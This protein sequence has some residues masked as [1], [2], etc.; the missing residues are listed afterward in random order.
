MYCNKKKVFK[1]IFC[2][3]YA[4]NKD[5]TQKFLHQIYIL[6]KFLYLQCIEVKTKLVVIT[7]YCNCSFTVIALCT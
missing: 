6:Q 3:Q 5:F 7:V 4:S 2:G 1:Y